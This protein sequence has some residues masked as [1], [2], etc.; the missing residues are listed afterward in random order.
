MPEWCIVLQSH[1]CNLEFKFY[2]LC[3]EGKY[4]SQP[5]RD[6]CMGSHGAYM[7]S[8][9]HPAEEGH[10]LMRKRWK[11]VKQ[12]TGHQTAF[13]HCGSPSTF[14]SIFALCTLS[15]TTLPSHIAICWL[16]YQSIPHVLLRAQKPYLKT[17]ALVQIS[18]G[19]IACPYDIPSFHVLHAR[20]WVKGSRA[21][22]EKNNR[23]FCRQSASHWTCSISCS[24]APL[25][26]L[27]L[28][29][30]LCSRNLLSMASFRYKQWV[31]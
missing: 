25:I 16:L 13:Q 18:P 17:S 15:I 11:G 4:F 29:N 28:Q 24:C 30:K 7:M 1:T 23:I 8:T 5:N 20:L 10:L 2:K 19:S 31:R 12:Q 14:S 21:T 9:W 26:P 6:D 27:C 22:C 3:S